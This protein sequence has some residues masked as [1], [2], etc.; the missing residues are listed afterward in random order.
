[1]V[2][3]LIH[4][5]VHAPELAKKIAPDA[6][7]VIYEVVEKNPELRPL[8]EIR[9][10]LTLGSSVYK[11]GVGGMVIRGY[12]WAPEPAARLINNFLSPGLSGYKAWQ[13]YRNIG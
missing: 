2:A 7:E 10:S 8:L 5:M 4:A 1:R 3:N 12:Y 13:I 9:P 6:V 11:M